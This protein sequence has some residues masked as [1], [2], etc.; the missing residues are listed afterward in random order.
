MLFSMLS[1]GYDR[2]A[3]PVLLHSVFEFCNGLE[4]GWYLMR[5]DGRMCEM[6][7]FSAWCNVCTGEMCWWIFREKSVCR[8]WL[9]EDGADWKQQK[10]G[11]QHKRLQKI[12]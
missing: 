6:L 8:K 12:K 11:R 2:T 10:A 7:E 1:A 5:F 4:L 3:D 9:Q